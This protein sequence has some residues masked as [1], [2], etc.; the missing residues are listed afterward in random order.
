MPMPSAKQMQITAKANAA[1]QKIYPTG[2]EPMMNM[3]MKRLHGIV[4]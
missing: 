2:F 1:Q 3:K 4:P